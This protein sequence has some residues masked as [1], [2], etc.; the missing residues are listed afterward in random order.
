MFSIRFAQESDLESICN[1]DA[2]AQQDHHRRDFTARA[3][4]SKSCY[5]ATDNHVLG[6]AVLEYT[7][8]QGAGR[9]IIVSDRWEL[10][11]A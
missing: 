5:M 2:V 7:L 8:E 3:V 6:Y 10:A 11:G 9:R 1:L 4:S